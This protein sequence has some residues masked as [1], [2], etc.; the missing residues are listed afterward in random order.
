LLI[1]EVIVRG[2]LAFATRWKAIAGFEV[3]SVIAASND[4]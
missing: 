1:D 4:N 2:G 3:V